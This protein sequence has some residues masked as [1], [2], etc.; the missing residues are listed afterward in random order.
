MKW[1]F[2][3]KGMIPLKQ[4]ARKVQSEI[5]ENRGEL[6]QKGKVIKLIVGK[7]KLQITL[8]PRGGRNS[9][10]YYPS[11]DEPSFNVRITPV[12]DLLGEKKV[13]E[14]LSKIQTKDDDWENM[15][16][17]SKKA[18]AGGVSVA[19]ATNSGMLNP[20]KNAKNPKLYRKK[21]REE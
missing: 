3:L 21:R 1:K 15:F 4:F 14:L 19:S 8:D 12:N 16:G 2:I 11:T 9:L 20:N 5:F 6:T 10:I 13:S 17:D 18:S 7:K